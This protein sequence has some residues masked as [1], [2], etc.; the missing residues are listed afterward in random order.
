MKVLILGGNGRMGPWVVAALAGRHTLRVTDVNDPPPAFAHEYRRLDVADGAA[1]AAAAAGMDAI[2]NL[3]VLRRDN[4]RAF[5]V[6]LRGNYHL[7][8]AAVRHGIRRVINTGPH[9]QLAGPQL[10]ENA[11]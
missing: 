8:A 2:I 6:N 3:S 1:V 11:E 4:R 9:Y 7:A 5:A 10:K